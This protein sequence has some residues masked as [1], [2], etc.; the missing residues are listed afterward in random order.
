MVT[1]VLSPNDI[2]AELTRITGKEFTGPGGNTVGK[3]SAKV[4][5]SYWCLASGM[6][7][8]ELLAPLHGILP[9]GT[10]GLMTIEKNMAGARLSQK[11]IFISPEAFGETPRSIL[12]Q[13][14][15][16]LP[17]HVA[18]PPPVYLR[19]SQRRQGPT[20]WSGDG[21][22]SPGIPERGTGFTGVPGDS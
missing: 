5:Q 6:E 13:M 18:A 19:P 12:P 2:T 17:K 22:N 15:G 4:N 10:Y 11:G 9:E 8:I 1:D 7:A 14:E 21:R 16:A 3:D 20:Q